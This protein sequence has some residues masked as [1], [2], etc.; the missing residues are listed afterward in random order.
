MKYWVGKAT[1]AM[2]PPTILYDRDC[3]LCQGSVAF[4]RRHDRRQ[5]FTYE[6]LQSDTGTSH[7]RTAGLPSHRYDTLLL[8][9]DERT[10][11]RSTA[12]LRVARMLGLPWSLL[13]AFILV[14]RPLRDRVYDLVARNRHRW[15][16]C[17]PAC[18]IPGPSGEPS[19]KGGPQGTS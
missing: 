15:S 18:S 13:Y 17:G 1:H 5:R 14:P 9:E 6:T 16:G 7:L 12:A 8:V 19:G 3:P 2:S 4:V 10:S 11:V